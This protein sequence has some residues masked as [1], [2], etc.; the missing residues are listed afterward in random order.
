MFNKQ[1]LRQCIFSLLVVIFCFSTTSTRS[2]EIKGSTLNSADGLFLEGVRISIE[3]TGI[4]IF[5]ERGGSF[6]IRNLKPGDYTLKATYIGYPVYTQSVNI[7]NQESSIRITIDYAADDIVELETFKVEGS[8]VGQ[9]K[10]INLQRSADNIVNVVSSDAIGQFVDRNAAEALQRLPG[11]SLEESQ[12]EG[13]FIIIRGADPTLN[14]VTI[15]GVNL[16][17]PEEDG[18]SV[19]LNIIST[20]QLERI[21]LVKS[22]LPDKSGNVIGGTVNLVTRSALDRGARFASVEG[23][24]TKHTIAAGDSYRFNATYGDILGKKENIGIQIS[25]NQSVDNRG[26]DTLKADTWNTQTRADLVS[27][28]DGFYLEGLQ[29]EDLT[30]R[31]ERTGIGG[32]LEYQ[33]GENHEFFVTASFNQFDDDEVLQE[34]RVNMS[35]APTSYT[36]PRNLTEE[37][38]LELGLDLNDP[39]VI[40]RLSASS[41]GNKL[42][43]LT[44]EEAVQLNTIAWDAETRNYTFIGHLATPTKSWRNT[45]TNDKI[46]TFQAGGKHQLG[47]IWRLD[48]KFYGSDAE[49]NWTERRVTLEASST[50]F[51]IRLGEDGYFPQIVEDLTTKLT[52]PERFQLNRE[53]GSA[54]DNTFFSSDQRKG[55]E[56]NLEAVYQIGKSPAKTKFGFAADFRDKEF[57]RNFNRFGSIDTSPIPQLTLADDV[58][59]G[60]ELETG[61]LSGRPEYDF[62]PSFDTAAVNAFIDDPGDVTFIQLPNDVTFNVTDAILKNYQAVEDISA[63]FLMQTLEVRGFKIIAGFRYEKTKNTFT[64]NEILTR[65][66]E[67][68]FFVSPAFWNR[69]PLEAFS[70]LTTSQRSYT[71]FLPAF[72]VIKNFSEN[73]KVKASITKTIGRPKFT[74]LVPRE[75]VSIAGARFGNDVQLPNFNL[76]AREATNIDFSFERYFERLGQF[77]VSGFHKKLKNSIYTESRIVD[78]GTGVAPELAAKYDSLGEDVTEWRT[79]QMVNAGDGELFGVEVAFERKFNFLPSPFDGFGLSFNT[80]FI[81]SKVKLLLEERFEEEVPLFKQSS[82]MGNLSVFFEKYGLLVRLALVWRGQ[83]LQGVRAGEQDIDNLTKEDRL[84]LTPDALDVY[85]DD[86]TR[87]DLTVKYRFRNHFTFF[88]EATNLNDEPL[89]RY[90]GNTSRLHSIQFTDTI[91]SVG[92]KWNL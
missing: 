36:K 48:Y 3:G 28:P 86:F 72:H 22:W 75:I 73:T 31:R 19:A 76:Q 85:V 23:A 74:D 54:A 12:G 78:A 41:E 79:T 70:Q 55:F 67:L 26:S 69:L 64:I 66:E 92:A 39:E 5:S 30:I 13:K 38:A 40:M 46:L 18:R 6:V 56:V 37:F 8:L 71:H 50:A 59:F 83:Y 29:F 58:F 24:F 84:N 91:F 45:V 25:Y 32:K 49:K 81:E 4:V 63:A 16:A 21:E 77:T 15:D 52:E 87:L 80:A 20:D 14:A 65:P 43:L 2:A 7:P 62:G 89:R 11:I 35:N 10:A 90:R 57:I 47:Q 88:F 17:T 33:L 27:F 1:I 42:S 9:A 34:T 60:G 68:P 82:S 51:E 61:F 44:F 53:E